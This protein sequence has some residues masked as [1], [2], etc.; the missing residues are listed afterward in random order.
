MA[1]HQSQLFAA[2][3]RVL[4]H[5]GSYTNIRGGHNYPTLV[6]TTTP[7]KPIKVLL[8]SGTN[9][10]K[11]PLGNWPLA[12][13]TMAWALEYA[14]YDTRFVFGE[15]SHSFRHGGAI[16]ADS[17]RWLA[18]SLPTGDESNL[19]IDRTSADIITAFDG[20]RINGP[21]EA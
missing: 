17:L 20:E 9:D 2:F 14:G 10:L 4:T 16:F 6:I 12:N 5:C 8:Q 3:G 7:L 1:I 18:S 15:G 21:I 13:Q 11:I 19:I